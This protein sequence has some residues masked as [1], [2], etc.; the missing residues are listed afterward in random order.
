MEYESQALN[1]IHR[2]AITSKNDCFFVGYIEGIVANDRVDQTELEPLLAECDALCR[3]VQDDDALEII[4]E[5]TAGHIM[6]LDELL[7]L[8]RQ[9][10]EVRLKSIDDTCPRS[11]ANRLLGY[12]AG[13]N[14][15]SIITT[16]EAKKLLDRVSREHDLSGDPRIS[17]LQHRLT[18]ALEDGVIDDGESGEISK[19]ITVLVGDSFSDTGI[20]SSEAV[21]VVHDLDQID[22][23]S[24]LGR[25]IVLTGAFRYGT[26]REIEDK[27]T[28]YG[29]EMKKT[30]TVK[31]DI[32][33]IGSEGSP[34]FTYKT[35]GGK[36]AKAFQ[37][38]AD[39]TLPRIYVEGQFR[40]HLT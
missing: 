24:V 14:C 28:S 36:L 15:D 21:P 31:T 12:C 38:R 6:Q 29:A 40:K 35:H 1:K 7:G 34:Y 3:Q 39:G 22:E 9:I 23:S 32:V 18:D 26:R 27:L 17:A 5:A 2:R 30:V 13:V 11:A 37:L 8:L 20:P 10:I 25:T 16:R 33:I 4:H 19:L